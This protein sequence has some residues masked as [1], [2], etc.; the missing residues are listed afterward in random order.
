M[1]IANRVLGFRRFSA[2]RAVGQ[3]TPEEARPTLPPP[4][5]GTPRHRPL[6]TRTSGT[7][8]SPV[9]RDS[10]TPP[11]RDAT[12]SGCSFLGSTRKK[13]YAKWMP[14]GG[15]SELRRLAAVFEGGDPDVDPETPD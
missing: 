3:T 5:A 13:D 4:V 14:D 11:P 7:R 15:R 9:E 2:E 12:C 8:G 6:P 10:E 1:I